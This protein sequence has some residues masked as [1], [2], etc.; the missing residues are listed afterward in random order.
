MT[1]F[2]KVVLIPADQVLQCGSGAGSVGIAA[3]RKRGVDDDNSDSHT[4]SDVELKRVKKEIMEDPNLDS[5][6]RLSL[7]MKDLLTGKSGSSA[8]VSV[9]Q[10]MKLLRISRDMYNRLLNDT[11]PYCRRLQRQ[12]ANTASATENVDLQAELQSLQQ[13]SNAKS[14]VNSAATEAVVRPIPQ[15]STSPNPP[16]PPPVSNR[17]SA[18]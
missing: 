8:N 16:P 2:T 18:S 13:S 5:A 17:D 1:S 11:L 7:H 10:K 6:A 4:I 3:N 12:N 9:E 14:T 15:Q